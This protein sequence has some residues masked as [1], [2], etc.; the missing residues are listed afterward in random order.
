MVKTPMTWAPSRIGTNINEAEG[1]LLSPKRS[2]D[3]VPSTGASRRISCGPSSMVFRVLK[4]SR[5]YTGGRHVLP[6]AFNDIHVQQDLNDVLLR[7]IELKRATIPANQFVCDIDDNL[8]SFFFR[9]RGVQLFSQF[10]KIAVPRSSIF[11]RSVTSRK[12]PNRSG[13]SPSRSTN[14]FATSNQTFFRSTASAAF[15]GAS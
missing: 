7:K 11:L 3:P 6:F 12:M 13:G 10:S 5:I 4:V 2:G 1:L 9:R 14:E 8:R 15:P